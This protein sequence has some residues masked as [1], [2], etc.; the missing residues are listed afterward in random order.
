M[1]M[2]VSSSGRWAAL[3]VCFGITW[4]I[5]R[6]LFVRTMRD[7]GPARRAIGRG[8]V[9]DA[10]LTDYGHLVFA[11]CVL[12]SLLDAMG[13]DGPRFSAAVRD[14]AVVL[15]AGGCALILWA[16]VKLARAFRG[17]DHPA[18]ITD[19]PYAWIRH[20]RYLS[21][22]LLLAGVALVADSPL[23]LLAGCVFVV[24]V[25]RRIAREERFLRGVHG[26]AYDRYAARTSR[27]LPWVY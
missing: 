25:L 4:A 27:L 10:F 21:W 20:P 7:V 23:G 12:V 15:F 24:L 16:D 17:A 1:S 8:G 14:G 18:V 11:G 2:I 9:Y 3:A 13:A 19:G 5:G 26:A 6:R 22:L